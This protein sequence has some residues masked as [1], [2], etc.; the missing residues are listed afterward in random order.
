MELYWRVLSTEIKILVALN[1][2]P[3]DNSVSEDEEVFKASCNLRLHRCDKP[4]GMKVKRLQAW[5]WVATRDES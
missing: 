1:Q 5:L 4:Y 2:F 3:I